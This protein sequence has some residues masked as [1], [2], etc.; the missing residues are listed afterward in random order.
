LILSLLE[1]MEGSVTF[2]C[3]FILDPWFAGSSNVG[4][5]K[6]RYFKLHVIHLRICMYVLCH[7]KIS[8]EKIFVFRIIYIVNHNMSN[9]TLTRSRTCLREMRWAFHICLRLYWYLRMKFKNKWIYNM[10][11]KSN[12]TPTLSRYFINILIHVFENFRFLL[13]CLEDLDN[14]LR[15]LNSR[16]F[17]IRGQ[18]ADVLPKFFKVNYSCFGNFGRIYS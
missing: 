17:V 6:W 18:P 8:Q 3:I 4:V 13:Q 1:G 12:K 15:K 7:L 5:N 9:S 11:K 10:V 14:S 2:R 16:L